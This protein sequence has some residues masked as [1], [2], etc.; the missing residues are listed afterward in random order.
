MNADDKECRRE[1]VVHIGRAGRQSKVPRLVKMAATL[2][3]RK[4]DILAWYDCHF[5][6]AKVKG[7][8]NKSSQK[9]THMNLETTNTSN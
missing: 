9:E 7:I 5:S 4:T 2:M 1:R 6:M 8:N 3:A